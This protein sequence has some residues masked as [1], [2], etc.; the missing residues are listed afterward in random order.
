[1]DEEDSREVTKLLYMIGDFERISDHAV[2]IIESAEEV[3]DKQIE[4]SA[5]AMDELKAMYGAIEE[6][7]AITEQAF[8]DKDM[9]KAHMVEPLEQVVDYLKEQIR[10]HHIIRLQKVE[11][12][13]EPG[14]VLSDILT[15]LE[16]VSD[17]CSNVA[18][19][20]IEMTEHASLDLHSYL[21]KV[22]RSG[23]DFD[24]MYQEYKEK[25]AIA[26]INKQEGI[27]K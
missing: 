2:N 8:V 21:H 13:I 9:T 15:N 25:Y 16:R 24:T 27:A 22:H 5:S 12:A 1:M 6:I 7:V 11:C 17:H 10:L 23:K 20:L 3:K 18:S 14:F 4:F 26:P 19:C